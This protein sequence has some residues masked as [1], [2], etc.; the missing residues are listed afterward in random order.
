MI[1]LK[2]FPAASTQSLASTWILATMMAGYCSIPLIL[3]FLS[4]EQEEGCHRLPTMHTFESD[5]FPPIVC[6]L[7]TFFLKWEV[8][9]RLLYH[10]DVHGFLL[11]NY[12]Y[13]VFRTS[14]ASPRIDTRINQ[15]KKQNKKDYTSMQPPSVSPISLAQDILSDR[16]KSCAASSHSIPL[17]SRTHN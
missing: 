3:S 2:S 10:D 14:Q 17:P 13:K 11:K 6:L 7:F 15:R 16:L 5:I 9:P 1:Q 8:K 12:E 4:S